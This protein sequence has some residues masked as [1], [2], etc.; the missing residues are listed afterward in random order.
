MEDGELSRLI[1]RARQGDEAAAVSLLR[2]F[3]N[4]VRLMVRVRLPRALRAQFDSMDFVQAVWKSVLA[5]P[6]ARGEGFANVA[7]FR[8]FLAG[9]ARNKVWEE[10]RRRTQTRKYDL[11]RE[12]PLYVRRNGRDQPRE[13]P[14]SDPSPSQ[15]A[16]AGDC[17][18]RLISGRSPREVAILEL[19]RLGLTFEEVADRLKLSDRTV[20]RVIAEARKRLESWEGDRP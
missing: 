19:R 4:D 13:L 3:E 10:Y 1:E 20:R 18:E 7:H 9:V 12:E 2:E 17:L 16:Q 6:E 14:A 15:E 11:S 5:D 8:G